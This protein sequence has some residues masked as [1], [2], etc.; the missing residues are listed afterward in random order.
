MESNKARR[1]KPVVSLRG[2]AELLAAV[3]G[4]LG[5]VP[6]ESI[7]LIAVGPSGKHVTQ[8]VRSDIPP[9][10]H[11]AAVA[12]QLAA[13]VVDAQPTFVDLVVVGGGPAAAD[14][15]PP[16]RDVAEA[17]RRSL[18]AAGVAQP[19]AFWVAE[20]AAD[21]RWQSYDDPKVG[22]SLPDPADSVLSAEL[23]G[24]GHVTFGS[25][26]EME[27][28][29]EPDAE[30]AVERR[31]KLIDQ[32][33]D[34]LKEWTPEK[35]AEA[36]AD[37]LRKSAEKEFSLSDEQIAELGIALSDGKIRDA[38]LA[39]ASPPNTPLAHQ[40]ARLWQCLAR[41]L[42]DPE[43]AEAACLA[44]F[45]AYQA[46]DGTLARI[47]LDVALQANPS[48]VLAGLLDRALQHGFHPRELRAL[49][50]HDEVGLSDRARA[51]A[52]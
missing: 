51:A 5:Y 30:A 19:G 2:P 27:A 29:F 12:E 20:L 17:V 16:R 9:P 38:C 1:T 42:P 28:L 47:A 45:A 37:A 44:A 48:H 39:T 3:P 15:S 21:R 34:T 52:A 43:R 41:A 25:R 23:A 36:I 13:T 49:A 7:V 26:A 24:L 11:V 10:S 31:S 22:G 35:G 50:E 14:G 8:C 4:L 33:I 32:R 6:E 18:R 40:A 46:G